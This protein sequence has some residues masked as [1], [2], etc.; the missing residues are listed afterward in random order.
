MSAWELHHGDCLRLLPTVADGAAG[1]VITDPPYGVAYARHS[2]PR[3]Q[4]AV[5]NDERPFIWWLAG[6]YRVTRDGG[7]LLCFHRW[8]VQDVWKMALE[9]AGFE[10]RSQ[11]VW[12]R[13]IHGS[14]DTRRD[15]APQHDLAWFAVKEIRREFRFPGKRPHSVVRDQKPRWQQLTHPTEKPLGLMLELVTTLC[16]ED[17]LV[18]DPFAGSGSTGEACIV[19]RRRF[20]GCELDE[21]HHRRARARLEQSAPLFSGRE[22]QAEFGG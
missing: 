4:R 18:V 11:L 16:P 21:G 14:G 6:A 19:S 20:W 13:E 5:L 3:E 8:D 22:T 2:G 1:V 15:L 12:D 17:G 10:V 7:A 9:A